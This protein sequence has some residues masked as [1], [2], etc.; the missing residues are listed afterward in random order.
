MCLSDLVVE[1]SYIEST[2]KC[3][4][5]WVYTRFP[6]RL[7]WAYLKSL[8]AAASVSRWRPSPSRPRVVP[9]VL[10][11]LSKTP[12]CTVTSFPAA[13][14]ATV[15]SSVSAN[16]A[17]I[18]PSSHLMFVRTVGSNRAK[19]RVHS[20]SVRN[21]PALRGPNTA[22]RLYH[23]TQFFVR[24]FTVLSKEW[25][26][27]RLFWNDVALDMQLGCSLCRYS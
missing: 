5:T 27:D 8:S 6:E 9:S 11:T 2:E 19:S 25:S 21:G 17:S 16:R 7:N 1:S 10:S 15:A 3:R 4:S 23:I 18:R 26:P 12:L 14:T 13:S 22:P 20:F 24:M